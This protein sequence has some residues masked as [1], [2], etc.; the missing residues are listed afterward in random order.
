MHMENTLTFNV[1]VG[2]IIT[3]EDVILYF[4]DNRFFF[5]KFYTSLGKHM[6]Y[7][8]YRKKES[9]TSCAQEDSFFT[10]WSAFISWSQN[11]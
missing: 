6:M 3:L 10:T 1:Q 9:S 11:D 7:V 8:L 5:C 4:Q 2:T